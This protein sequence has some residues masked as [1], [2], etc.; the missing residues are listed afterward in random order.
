MDGSPHRGV[1]F[2]DLDGTL[3][4]PDGV[5][6]RVW[7]PLARLLRSGFRV[8]V[9]TGR[10]GRGIAL[11]IAHRLDPDGLHVF[12]S[13]AVVMHARGDVVAHAPMPR[14]A[15]EALAAVAVAERATLEAYTA[16]ARYLVPERDPLVVAHEEL[17]GFGAEIVAW[18][19]AE[20]L[21]RMQLVVPHAAWPRLAESARDAL[22]AV[23]A[24]EG[25]SP[26]MP[27]VSFVSMTAPGVS[28]G[29]G[30]R[31]VLARY[32]LGREQAAMAGDNLNDLEAFDAVGRVFVPADGDPRARARAD[33]II[34]SP[35]DGGVADAA[36]ALLAGP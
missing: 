23:S 15:I 30:V 7:A 13:G 29:T 12:E 5:A 28:K 26:R 8:A 14:A 16:D 35:R 31:A 2:V 3:V 10:P 21:V 34:A 36:L 17:L 25:R 18:P 9:C 1:L 27:G 24:H 33:V 6:E 4:G 22:A 32:G 11:D 20:P 19:P